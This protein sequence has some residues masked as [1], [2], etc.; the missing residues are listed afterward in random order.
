MVKCLLKKIWHSVQNGADF[1]T[2]IMAVLPPFLL[3]GTALIRCY[4]NKIAQTMNM[5]KTIKVNN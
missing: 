4:Q 1:D 5:Y 3:I 2:S